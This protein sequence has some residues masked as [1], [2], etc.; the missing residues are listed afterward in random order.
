MG[1]FVVPGRNG[2]ID[3]VKFLIQQNCLARRYPLPAEEEN[4][5]GNKR[6][7][8]FMSGRDIYKW[9]RDRMQRF[10]ISAGIHE[11]AAEY[12][13]KDIMVCLQVSLEFPP[14]PPGGMLSTVS[15][16]TSCL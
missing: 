2:T 6:L 14:V 4:N 7:P 16:M 15:Y 3:E 12:I 5:H 11:Q 13:A 9:D 1:D 8:V 10:L